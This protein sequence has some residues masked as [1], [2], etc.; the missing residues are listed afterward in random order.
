MGTEADPAPRRLQV[1]VLPP[2]AR[3]RVLG[4]LRPDERRLMS[5]LCCSCTTLDCA[6]RD[7]GLAPEEARI[8]WRRVAALVAAE[9]P[10][11]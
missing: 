5:M 4:Q 2:T 10:S 7:L 11:R 6:A 1:H 3:A 9:G 8:M